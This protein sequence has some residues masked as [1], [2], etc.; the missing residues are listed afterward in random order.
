VSYEGVLRA[1]LRDD[2]AHTHDAVRRLVEHFD[3]EVVSVSGTRLEARP[4]PAR[5]AGE[6]LMRHLQADPNVVPE[7][8]AWSR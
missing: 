2:A 1:E 4:A 3:G 6:L 7:S 8:V 5:S